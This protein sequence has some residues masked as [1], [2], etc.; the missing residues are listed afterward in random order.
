[1]P[2]LLLPAGICTALGCELP[3]ISPS[4][5]SM[6]DPKSPYPALLCAE[7]PSNGTAVM[8]LG[9]SL[10]PSVLRGAKGLLLAFQRAAACSHTAGHEGS[11]P[12]SAPF[13]ECPS[14]P[15]LGTALLIEPMERL[16]CF[17]WIKHSILL[18][19]IVFFFFVFFFFPT[20]INHFAFQNPSANRA[21]CVC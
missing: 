9:S 14:K 12:H 8:E 2:L 10:G 17:T 7:L 13:L 1:M 21:V 15:S 20:N 16:H 4:T 6:A 11:L 5:Q 18:G 3:C 19:L